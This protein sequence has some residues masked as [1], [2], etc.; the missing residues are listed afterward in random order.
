[1]KSIALICDTFVN[2]IVDINM[3]ATPI[4]D[5][6]MLPPKFEMFY[7]T[8]DT[9]MDFIANTLLS[10]EVVRRILIALTRR[11]RDGNRSYLS[12]SRRPLRGQDRASGV[13]ST[14]W[15]GRNPGSAVLSV[16]I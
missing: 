7:A 2:E 6:F 1:M 13:S 9:G 12:V 16:S 3:R 5:D 14:A 10:V 8:S 15:L 4:I 11:L